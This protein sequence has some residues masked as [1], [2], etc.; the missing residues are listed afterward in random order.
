V[1]TGL[2]RHGPC[3]ILSASDTP[4]FYLRV[5]SMLMKELPLHVYSIDLSVEQAVTIDQTGTRATAA[6]WSTGGAG[7][8]GAGRLDGVRGFVRGCTDQFISGYHQVNLKALSEH[9]IVASP[10]RSLVEPGTPRGILPT[11]TADQGILATSAAE[12][13]ARHRQRS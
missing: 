10:G 1:E 5:G 2:E 13:N 6:T 11:L 8:V 9:W 7:A 4:Y 3:P 12:R